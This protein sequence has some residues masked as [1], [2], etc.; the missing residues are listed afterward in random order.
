VLSVYREFLPNAPRELNGFFAYTMVPPAPPFPEELHLREVAGI[1][2]CYVGPEADAHA[3]MAPLM[4]AVP[5]PLMH[6][7]QPMPHAIAPGCVRRALPK[8]HQWYWRADFR[9]RNPG[10]GDRH[11]SGVRQQPADDAV[12]DAPVPDRRSRPRRRPADTAWSYRDVNWGSV[13]A[14]VDPDPA[15]AGTIRDWSVG[16]NE[17]LHPH[18]SGGAYLNMIMDEGEER[19]RASYR[20]NY[21]RL[22]RIK[23]PV[24]PGEPVPGSTRTSSP[25]PRSAEAAEGNGDCLSAP[26]RVP[27]CSGSVKPFVPPPATSTRVRGRVEQTARPARSRSPIPD[28]G[29]LRSA[30][31]RSS[32]SATRFSRVVSPVKEG[33][34]AGRLIDRRGGDCGYL[35][36]FRSTTSRRRAT[37]VRAESVREVSTCRSRTSRRLHLHPADMRGAIGSVS[38]PSPPE[39]WRWGRPGLGVAE[40]LR[41]EWSGQRSLWPKPARCAARWE[42]VLG[43]RIGGPAW[44]SVE[45]PD[46]RGLVE[47]LLEAD[48]GEPFQLGRRPVQL[49]VRE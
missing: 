15:N 49:P 2:W 46:E 36:M 12:D 39:A 10:R 19:I 24:R 42:S 8:G 11:P 23:A 4:E 9:H 28:V 13:F 37:R 40:A 41:C 16:Y 3:A 17:A 44:R 26:G 47:V 32:A 25:P 20:D 1:V 33:T 14:G 48:D 21:D 38:R 18:S 34:A 35:T 5:A 30:Q 7:V 22:A 31:R 29:P 6:G 27:G 43:A 45:G